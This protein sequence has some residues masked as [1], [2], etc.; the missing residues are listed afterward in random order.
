MSEMPDWARAIDP[1]NVQALLNGDALSN[2]AVNAGL[3]ALQTP[4]TVAADSAAKARQQQQ[5][6]D[7]QV[8]AK[9]GEVTPADKAI[10]DNARFLAGA[11]ITTWSSAALEGV[12]NFKSSLVTNQ[13]VFAPSLAGNLMWAAT[14]I[15]GVGSKV[16]LSFVGA[17]AG[18]LEGFK[19]SYDEV[20]GPVVGDVK[21]HL[22][23]VTDDLLNRADILLYPALI[24]EGLSN[25]ATLDGKHQNIF[26]WNVLFPSI[27]T[28]TG[29]YK[30]ATVDFVLGNL[31]AA[32]HDAAEKLAF[33][34][35]VWI[36]SLVNVGAA[37]LTGPRWVFSQ[38]K[39]SEQ[40]DDPIWLWAG[41]D[42]SLDQFPT[43]VGDPCMDPNKRAAVLLRIAINRRWPV[44]A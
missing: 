15:E 36:A 40:T 34:A 5:A 3:Y 44:N 27:K 32:D 1:Q 26:I 25:F 39:W 42:V 16:L 22:D 20:I 37:Y 13:T 10:L 14:S 41:R 4:A 21:A 18:S 24:Q 29:D 30:P 43:N 17:T 38:D 28:T 12:D 6:D 19:P 23:Q 33:Y 11:L 35:R 9:I 31:Q 7:A 8:L 2:S